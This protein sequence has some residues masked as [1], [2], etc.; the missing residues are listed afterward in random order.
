MDQV[1]I[2][3]GS[4]YSAETA[5]FL[6]KRIS[7]DIPDFD[8]NKLKIKNK[9]NKETLVI[10]GPYNSINSVKNDY[11]QLKTFGFEELDVFL[12]E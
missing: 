6:K 5:N 8:I 11:I 3:I 1:Y 2:L 12:N 9:N 4:F 7:K 10:S